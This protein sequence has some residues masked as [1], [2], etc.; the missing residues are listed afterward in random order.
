MLPDEIVYCKCGAIAVCDGSA[1]RMWP[2]GSDDFIRV[3]DLGNE[4]LVRYDKKASEPEQNPNAKN[5]Q[6]PVTREELIQTL[7]STIE[8]LEKL[9]LHH[10][11]SIDLA[12]C[13]LIISSILK[14]G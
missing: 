3:D 2:L 14:R 8:T 1:M 10:V 11:T 7:N 5:S 13:M 6:E 12:N 9:P 4:I